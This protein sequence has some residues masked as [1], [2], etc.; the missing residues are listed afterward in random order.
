[1][2]GDRGIDQLQAMRLESRQSA[3]FVDLHEATV[4]DHVG[5]KNRNQLTF[6]VDHVIKPNLAHTIRS[7]GLS[8]SSH[9]DPDSRE[10]I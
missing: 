5:G 9:S 10:C 4:A 1:V 7:S 6:R 3:R 8:E 2:L